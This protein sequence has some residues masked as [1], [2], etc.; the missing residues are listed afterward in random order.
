M[1]QQQIL[2]STGKTGMAH[3][4]GKGTASAEGTKGTG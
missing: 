3:F 1:P 2:L 4:A